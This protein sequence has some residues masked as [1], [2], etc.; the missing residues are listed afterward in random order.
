MTKIAFRRA[1][2]GTAS[3]PSPER[4]FVVDGWAATYRDANTSGM[5]Q[6]EDWY[7][8]MIP[9]INKVLDKPEVV[10]IVASS[11]LAGTGA[12][13]LGFIVAD[14]ADN[15]PLV[16]YVMTKEHYRR[17][18]HGRLWPSAGLARQLFGAIAIDPD[19][20]MNYVC[21]TPACRLLERKIPYGKWRPNL[22][23]FPKADR[24]KRP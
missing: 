16:Y 5:I 21:S 13:L 15:P 20:P 22:G 9:Q 19:R 4:K 1:N 3:D 11:S 23:K 8:V 2:L 6:V 12:D 14:P 7:S 17:G 24:K 10:T 18:G